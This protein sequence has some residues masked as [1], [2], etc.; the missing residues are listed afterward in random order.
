MSKIKYKNCLLA[1]HDFTSESHRFTASCV[2]RQR[3]EDYRTCLIECTLSVKQGGLSFSRLFYGY[4]LNI[5]DDLA[6]ICTSAEKL[7]K[8]MALKDFTR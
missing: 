3:T 7:S 2:T 8:T 4:V 5:N 6:G 1:V